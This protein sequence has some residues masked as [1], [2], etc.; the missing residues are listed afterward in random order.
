M[1]NTHSVHTFT[2]PH[3]HKH[4]HTRTL[5][6]TSLWVYSYLQA[7]RHKHT[8]ILTCTHT[9]CG[10]PGPAKRSGA[11]GLE[12][13]TGPGIG[14]PP[15]LLTGCL[16]HPS[17]PLREP[18]PAGWT[19]SPLGHLLGPKADPSL[20]VGPTPLAP[21]PGPVPD[22]C[23]TLARPSASPAGR[24]PWGTLGLA[25]CL[26]CHLSLQLPVCLLRPRAGLRLQRQS[27]A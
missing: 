11:G 18:S 21:L 10:T 26:P 23:P 24:A 6:H 7:L 22:A 8:L 25:C 20:P 27:Q 19:W 3:A 15:L 14:A 1:S 13:S 5:I 16:H 9:H 17:H 4:C 2:E 12:G